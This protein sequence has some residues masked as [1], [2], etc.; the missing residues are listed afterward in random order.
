M[1][2]SS[3][4][5]L[6]TKRPRDPLQ[7]VYERL[8]AKCL[9]FGEARDKFHRVDISQENRDFQRHPSLLGIFHDGEDPRRVPFQRACEIVRE[10]GERL[11][12]LYGRI[13]DYREI[14]GKLVNSL[15]KFNPR[16]AI[17]HEY[18]G[19]SLIEIRAKI[20][21]NGPTSLSTG[22]YAIYDAQS[23]NQ[24]FK[25]RMA[26]LSQIEMFD[27][28]FFNSL[29]SCVGR[30]AGRYV[31]IA[32]SESRKYQSIK[33]AQDE[34]FARLMDSKVVNEELR[35]THEHISKPHSPALLL[36]KDLCAYVSQNLG[37]TLLQVDSYLKDARFQDAKLAFLSFLFREDLYYRAGDN[38]PRIQPEVYSCA[39]LVILELAGC[40][41]ADPLDL[42]C[43]IQELAR[44]RSDI[45]F[46][47]AV[48]ALLKDTHDRLFYSDQERG[49]LI[50]QGRAPIVSRSKKDT[51]GGHSLAPANNP[52]LTVIVPA[53]NE[54]D[55]I[56]ATLES[57]VKYLD[58]RGIPYEVIVADDG[59]TDNTAELVDELAKR[60]PQVRCERVEQ[61]TGKG[62]A[63]RRG[64]QLARGEFVL[65]TDAD[66]ATPI[67]ELERLEK[68]LIDGDLQIAIGSRSSD[69]TGA[70]Q[71]DSTWWRR[72]VGRVF[73]V[74]VSGVLLSG[75]KDTQCGFKL[76]TSEAA[77]FLSAEQ[78]SER[79]GFDVE[80]L[81]MA[82]RA[83]MQIGEVPVNWQD[84]PGSKVNVWRDGIK[85]FLD[86][87]KFRFQHRD[88]NPES[89]REYCEV[90]REIGAHS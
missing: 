52:K 7:L 62:D 8:C 54:R 30:N 28:R 80:L 84:Q 76:F 16:S 57:I 85:M 71:V 73:N 22:L 59:S 9:F 1:S 44:N 75:V 50:A 10:A 21:G 65:F 23:S 66:G 33:G 19:Q 26:V 42:K 81:Y 48:R 36:G 11:G 55:R 43:V 87:L 46:V 77:K 89:Y 37:G 67:E 79:F 70:T 51:Y 3:N 90:R 40:L 58:N 5:S 82:R 25:Y 18:L 69:G 72:A 56:S 15:C 49:E 38:H 24:A 86:L 68:Q 20:S 13:Y 17:H 63:V 39:K 4:Q 83:K 78:K 64:M 29:V 60:H 32:G 45:G 35:E 12:M 31:E 47:V 14:G 41:K 27:R 2:I 34:I 88:I 74:A 6:D 53:Y 61:N